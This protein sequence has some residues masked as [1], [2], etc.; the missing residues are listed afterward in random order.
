[1]NLGDDRALDGQLMPG[2]EPAGV[3]RGLRGSALPFHYNRLDQ[4]KAIVDAHRGE[5]GVIVMEPQR[6]ESP[7][8]GFLEAGRD[9]AHTVGP[10]LIFDEVTTG[11]RMTDGGIHTLLG[12]N[13]DIAVFAKSMANGYPMAAVIGRASVVEAGQ[14][15]FLT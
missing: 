1:A 2:L 14:A 6:G 7:A 10:V 9:I 5:V 11:F 15:T 3:P 4:L 13:P 8:P 12:V